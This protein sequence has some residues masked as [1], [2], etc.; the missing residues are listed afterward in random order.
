MGYPHTALITGA[1]S[2]IGLELA[3]I[4]AQKGGN[5]VLVARSVDR[6]QRL[7]AELEA[8]HNISVTVI[9]ADLAD[10]G[11]AQQIFDQTQPLGIEIDTLI[12]NAGFGGHGLFHQR[13]LAAEQAMMQVNMVSLTTLTHLYVQGMVARRRGRILNV[14][15]TA[16]FI[17][18]PLQAVYY[19]SKAF[20]T[21][22][23]QGIAEELKDYGITVTALCPGPVNTGFAAVSNLEGIDI[24]K[25]AK[26]ARSV[27]AFGYRAMERGELVA[28]NEASLNIALNWMAPMMP[29]KLVLKASRL[30]MEKR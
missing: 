8:R 28:V 21:S 24:F 2:G 30:S 11:A 18:G 29:R 19:A 23:S 14:S 6:L 20:V 17:P 12:N 3:R 9:G 1:S 7:K 13:E 16:S 4:H 5:L 25:R 27:A 10:A 15:S 26:S 22:F